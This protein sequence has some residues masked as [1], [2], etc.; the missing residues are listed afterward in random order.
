MNGDI[1]SNLAMSTEDVRE[2]SRNTDMAGSTFGYDDTITQQKEDYLHNTSPSELQSS[3]AALEARSRYS[4]IL[5][6]GQMADSEM[7]IFSF[8]T[9]FPFA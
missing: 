6:F 4:F 8:Q 2:L 9:S 1:A 5:L 3:W 7:M